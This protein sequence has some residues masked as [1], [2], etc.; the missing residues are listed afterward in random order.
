MSARIDI[1]N[2]VY[3]D[4]WSNATSGRPSWDT[5][6]TVTT[7]TGQVSIMPASKSGFSTFEWVSIALGVIAIAVAMK[8]VR[9]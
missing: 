4:G 1:Q 9:K 8:G 3:G 2:G 5:T 6:Q 7:N